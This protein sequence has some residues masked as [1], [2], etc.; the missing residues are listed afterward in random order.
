[1]RTPEERK[2]A[3]RWSTRDGLLY[4]TIPFWFP[5][6]VDEEHG[7]FSPVSPRRLPPSD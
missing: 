1:M 7:G 3:A 5:R 4:D 6:S 2:T